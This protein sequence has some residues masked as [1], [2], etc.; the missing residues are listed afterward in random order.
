MSEVHDPAWCVV[1]PGALAAHEWDDELVVYDD[2]DGHTH[3]LAPLAGKVLLAL[4]E[5]RDGLS[6][7]MLIERVGQL[8]AID[9][10]QVLAPAVEE[11]LDELGRLALIAP[12]AA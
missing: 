1:A 8:L 10:A 9:D 5:C 7:A 4:L 2:L 11:A 12:A 6:D 3:H